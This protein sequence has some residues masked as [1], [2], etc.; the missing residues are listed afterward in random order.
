MMKKRQAV[1]KISG[2]CTGIAALGYLLK[3]YV[4]KNE[5]TR[6]EMRN[7]TERY[8]SY[9]QLTSKWLEES[10]RGHRIA[11]VLIKM[12]YRNIAVY[13]KGSL[14]RLLSEG[15][16]G[17]DVKITCW[18]E[19]DTE[20]QYE[21]ADGIKVISIH[22][23]KECQSA[24]AVIVTPVFDYAEIKDELEQNDCDAEILSLEDIIFDL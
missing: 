16:R 11:D 13:G 7:V 12:G 17:S 10:F 21:D 23:I 9:Y 18:I 19:K 8:M 22:D 24:D 4:K 5:D 15:I 2:L 3:K 14:G 1:I 20:E 6:K